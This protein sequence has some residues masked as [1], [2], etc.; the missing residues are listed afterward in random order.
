MCLNFIWTS[1]Q[2]RVKW[3]KLVIPK[4]L[5]GI[6]LPD[7]RKYYWSCHLTRIIDWHLHSKTKAWIDL[8]E[9]AS[10]LPLHHLP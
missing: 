9:T 7:I 5:G 4:L 3:D 1:K 8:E 10:N 2:P 6:G